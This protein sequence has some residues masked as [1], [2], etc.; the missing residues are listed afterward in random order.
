MENADTR[1][2]PALINLTSK[3]LNALAKLPCRGLELLLVIICFES[4]NK[5]LLCARAARHE[6]CTKNS[7]SGQ[8]HVDPSIR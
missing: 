5:V 7:K 6:R 2:Y 4:F 8:V 3:I 1:I